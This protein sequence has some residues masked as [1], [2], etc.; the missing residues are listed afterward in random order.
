MSSS[1]REQ[2]PET[3]YGLI[4]RA[5]GERML[6]KAV[7]SRCHDRSVVRRTLTLRRVRGEVVLQ[8]ETLRTA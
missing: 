3:L 1:I 5:A 7:F 8:L 6:E 2:V 4:Y